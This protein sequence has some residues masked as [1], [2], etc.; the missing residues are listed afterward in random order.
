MKKLLN[1]IAI[2]L[3]FAIN[4]VQ[5]ELQCYICTNCAQPTSEDLRTSPIATDNINYAEEYVISRN[6]CFCY[7]GK[8]DCNDQYSA[9]LFDENIS[10]SNRTVSYLCY[11]HTYTVDGREVVDRGCKANVQNETACSEFEAADNC[12]ACDTDGCNSS[13]TLQFS[14]GLLICT[15]SV[16]HK[17]MWIYI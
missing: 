7:A 1:I 8:C 9:I 2:A 16:L 5:T 17:Q 6:K 4:P 11:K 14:I 13:F 12:E 10:P 3:L 15:I